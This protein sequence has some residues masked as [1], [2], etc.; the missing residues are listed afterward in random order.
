MSI[1]GYFLKKLIDYDIVPCFFRW[2]KSVSGIGRIYSD[3]LDM[4]QKNYGIKG[5]KQ[6]NNVMYD[7]GLNQS[8]EI[9]NKLG[10]EKNLEGCAYV[11]LSM[12]RVFGIKSKI[13]KKSNRR[14]VIHIS[15]CCWGR[16][17]KGW[18]P[19]TCASISQYELGLIR[20]IMPEVKHVY[21]KKHTLGNDV[22]EMIISR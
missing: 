17:R 10:L 6:M 15:D 7:I 5:I 16:K 2:K 14:I 22:C 9:L 8:L 20:G 4:M 19:K 1:K 13:V 11:L 3:M 21:T 18:T 12:H